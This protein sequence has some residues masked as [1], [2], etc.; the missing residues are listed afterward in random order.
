MDC[1]RISERFID[2]T[3]SITGSTTRVSNIL[4]GVE[5]Q[6]EEAPDSEVFDVHD[7]IDGGLV[8]RDRLKRC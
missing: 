6:G 1:P 7:I 8:D 2:A 3:P 5:G 4:D